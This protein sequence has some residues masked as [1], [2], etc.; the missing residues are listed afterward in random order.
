MRE[1]G[2][3]QALFACCCCGCLLALM[4]AFDIAGIVVAFQ[5][6]ADNKYCA[7]YNETNVR[8]SAYTFL[9]VGGFTSIGVFMLAILCLVSGKPPFIALI[10]NLFIIIWAGLSLNLYYDSFWWNN[11]SQTPI[12]T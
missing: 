3:S 2:P 7:T 10:G 6:Y 11:C 8:I 12:G 9:L 1:V 4:F 5:E